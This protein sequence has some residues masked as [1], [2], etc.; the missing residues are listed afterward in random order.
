MEDKEIIQ[1][2]HKSKAINYWIW[3][4]SAIIVIYPFSIGPVILFFRIFEKMG[5]N[6][7]GFLQPFIIFYFPI[8]VIARKVPILQNILQAYVDFWI[9]LAGN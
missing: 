8:I 5:Y 6:I 9:K 7:Q 2:E 4:I 1:E 3:S